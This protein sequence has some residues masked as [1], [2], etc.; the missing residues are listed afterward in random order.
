MTTENGGDGA[1]A[2]VGGG[3]G[4]GAQTIRVKAEDIV[5]IQS[6]LDVILERLAAVD[7]G[8]AD[9]DATVAALGLDLEEIKEVVRNRAA[10]PP[11]RGNQAGGAREDGSAGVAAEPGTR[12]LLRGA[13]CVPRGSS[14]GD[15]EDDI[16]G[17]YGRGGRCEGYETDDRRQL[18]TKIS[19]KEC[20][21]NPW[22][23]KEEVKTWLNRAI[24]T[25][26]RLRASRDDIQDYVISKLMEPQ[27]RA[28]V[29][30]SARLLPDAPFVDVLIDAR[31][32]LLGT[33]QTRTRVRSWKSAA[34]ALKQA[35]NESLSDFL[36]VSKLM[37]PQLRAHGMASA[38]LLPDAPFIDV[39]IDAGDKLLGTC[40]Q[41]RTRRSWK[42]AARALNQAE[43]ES[44]TDFLPKLET[45]INEF[46][47][48][49]P[50]NADDEEIFDIY[51]AA[52]TADVKATL[53]TEHNLWAHLDVR[54]TYLDKV[55]YLRECLYAQRAKEDAQSKKRMLVVAVSRPPVCSTCNS[56]DHS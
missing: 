40:M 8:R 41:T 38:R 47:E 43:N 14:I 26:R 45:V 50:E 29:V 51:L 7:A 23:S 46:V 25:V 36:V 42:S 31:D 30:A 22:K 54:E 32:K 17:R 16:G 37:E 35:D 39:L 18:P 19:L 1:G 15:D 27:L 48:N 49:D 4:P 5:K 44:L 56:R 10:A 12:A 55:R 13:V 34:R 52:I 3:D 28:H 2:Q 53:E 11:E 6:T 24:A 21:C 9:T 20:L 33:M